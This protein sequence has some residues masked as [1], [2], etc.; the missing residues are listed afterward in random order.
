[1]SVLS[2]R[3]KLLSNYKKKSER[4]LC[5]ILCNH[6]LFY[7]VYC[8]YIIILLLYSLFVDGLLLCTVSIAAATAAAVMFILWFVVQ[9]TC[10]TLAIMTLH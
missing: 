1:M 7:Y 4:V 6:A 8:V 9:I 3:M 5:D 10:F 2:V